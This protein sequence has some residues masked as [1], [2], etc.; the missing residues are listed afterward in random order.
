[1]IGIMACGPRPATTLAIPPG[2]VLCLYTDG[3]VERRGELIDEGLERLR[4]AVAAG[5]PE[6]ACA[7]VTGALVGRQPA[8]DD[9]A[10]LMFRR[11]PVSS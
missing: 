9:I 10:L 4:Q 8:R 6:A 3:L 1:M 2:A 5:P 7:A 11:Q